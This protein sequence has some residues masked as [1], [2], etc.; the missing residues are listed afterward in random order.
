MNTIV[1]PDMEEG[2]RSYRGPSCFDSS[3]IVSRSSFSP[4]TARAHGT[5]RGPLAFGERGSV[6]PFHH[7]DGFDAV[8]RPAEVLGGA[9]FGEQVAGHGDQ[10]AFTEVLQVDR[11]G[12]DDA[13]AVLVFFVDRGVAEDP[14]AAVGMDVEELPGDPAAVIGAADLALELIL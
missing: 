10:V 7:V 11:R 5:S 3:F 4:E 2:P 14:L 6:G 13:A 1:Q 9:G 8:E 12:Q